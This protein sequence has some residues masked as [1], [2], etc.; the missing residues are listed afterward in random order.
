MFFKT[1]LVYLRNAVTVR[2]RKVNERGYLV[3]LHKGSNQCPAILTYHHAFNETSNRRN[4]PRNERI[5][6][7]TS[8]FRKF[9]CKVIESVSSCIEKQC[10]G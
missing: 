7:L 1:N 6:M 2:Q 9:I 3:K 8:N 5:V 10:M 4:R